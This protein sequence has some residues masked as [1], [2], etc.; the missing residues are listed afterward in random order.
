ML[1]LP[2]AAA[3]PVSSKEKWRMLWVQ[4]LIWAFSRPGMKHMAVFWATVSSLLFLLARS[5]AAL[6]WFLGSDPKGPFT[7]VTAATS[8]FF[9]QALFPEGLP[10]KSFLQLS[11]KEAAWW[12]IPFKCQNSQTLY[13]EGKNPAGWCFWQLCKWL[14]CQQLGAGFAFQPACLVLL[15]TL[16]HPH[17]CSWITDLFLVHTK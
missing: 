16:L 13:E 15:E 9:T 14:Q 7:G 11:A 1:P 12:H 4:W 5:C 6:L 17:S 2:L 8:V 10:I 3:V